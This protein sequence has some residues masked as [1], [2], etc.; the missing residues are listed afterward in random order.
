MKD[1]NDD[2]F[3]KIFK[4][5]TEGMEKFEVEDLLEAVEMMEEAVDARI[6]EKNFQE[7][8]DI[9]TELLTRIP[10]VTNERLLSDDFYNRMLPALIEGQGENSSYTI[11]EAYKKWKA[12][13]PE[14]P[15]PGDFA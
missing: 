3:Q 14:G 2:P 10:Q 9:A 12:Q 5:I 11:T 8:D 15:K 6:E 4:D 7:A 13:P 1:D